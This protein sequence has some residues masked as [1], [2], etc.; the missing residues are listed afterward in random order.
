VGWRYLGGGHGRWVIPT[1]RLGSEYIT[2]FVIGERSSLGFEWQAVELESPAAPLFTKAGDPTKQLTHAIRQI[3]DWRVWLQRNQNYAARSKAEGGLGLTDIV[4]DVPG[5][6]LIGRRAA[7][8]PETQE[9]RR[10]MSN[11]LQ[12]DI[13]TYDFLL[14]SVDGRARVMK[15]VRASRA[16]SRREELRVGQ[17]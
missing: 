1:K 4:A 13:H 16:R 8:D 6:I 15:K 3:Q 12:I 14:D 2:D 9:R 10:Q 17:A 11:D 7:V 5:L